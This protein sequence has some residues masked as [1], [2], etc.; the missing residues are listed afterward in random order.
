MPAYMLIFALPLVIVNWV[1]PIIAFCW[2]V[3][4]GDYNILIMAAIASFVAA[5]AYVLAMIPSMVLL[6]PGMYLI[7]KSFVVF[8]A[9]GFI[10]L[11]IGGFWSYILMGAWTLFVFGYEPIAI[12]ERSLPYLLLAYGVSTAP[13]SFMASKEPADNWGAASAT[14][15]NQLSSLALLLLLAFSKLNLV[16]VLLIFMAIILIGYFLMLFGGLIEEI[17]KKPRDADTGE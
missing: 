7:Q 17:T 9:L 4:L 2:I 12:T 1:A 14:L 15:L 6:L 10:L 8:R 16:T 3:Y 13:F 5:F 11:S